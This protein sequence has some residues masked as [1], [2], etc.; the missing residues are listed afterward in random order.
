[1][2]QDLFGSDDEGYAEDTGSTN[3]H[4]RTTTLMDEA[5]D[6][7]EI[8][9]QIPGLSLWHG[10]L[11]H[12]QQMALTQAIID[13]DIFGQGNQA[14]RFGNLGPHLTELAAYIKESNVLPV[15]LASRAPLFDQAIYNRYN[16]GMESSN[17]CTH[18]PAF[19]L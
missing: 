13:A 3:L 8:F 10:A 6:N 1:M 18:L 2:W 16:K 5:S 9:D 12:S 19:L 14:M 4:C 11:D 7:V 17:S 15:S